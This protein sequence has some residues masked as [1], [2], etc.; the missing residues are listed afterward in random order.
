MKREEEERKKREE[1]K[2]KQ[3]GLT[4]TAKITPAAVAADGGNKD[5]MKMAGTPQQKAPALAQAAQQGQ[6]LADQDQTLQT[7]QEEKTFENTATDAAATQAREFSEKM[8]AFGS[9]GKRFENLVYQDIAEGSAGPASLD[10]NRDAVKNLMLDTADEG[11]VDEAVQVIQDYQDA[12]KRR[13]AGEAV[14]PNEVLKAGKKYFKDGG[15]G[16][17]DLLKDMFP[18]DVELD[19]AV[20]SNIAEET[21]D[22]EEMTF[23]ALVEHGIIVGFEETLGISEDD[24]KMLLG[25]DWKSM[26]PEDVNKAVA[27]QR[28]QN[29]NR[30]GRI[31]NQLNNPSLDPVVRQG[32]EEELQRLGAMGV[33]NAEQEAYETGQKLKDSDKFIVDGKVAF[34]KDYLDDTNIMNAVKEYLLIT[35]EELKAAKIEEMGEPTKSMLKWA[36]E[37][38]SSLEQLSGDVDAGIK[39]FAEIQSSNAV[40][41]TGGIIKERPLS[42]KVM[43][44]LGFGEGWQSE[45][46][47]TNTSEMAKALTKLPKDAQLD[48]ATFLNGLPESMLD[49]LAGMNA[50]EVNKIMT[51][52]KDG[53]HTKVLNALKATESMKAGA[54][55]S[56]AIKAMFGGLAEGAKIADANQMNIHMTKLQLRAEFGDRKA[57]AELAMLKNYFVMGGNEVTLNQDAINKLR[58]G[59]N[60][61]NLG[62]DLTSFIDDA[63]DVPDL[64]LGSKALES[65]FAM[66]SPN[67]V[68]L[69]ETEKTQVI[70]DMGGRSLVE[71][72]Q[73]QSLLNKGNG[74]LMRRLGLDPIEFVKAIDVKEDEVTRETM[75]PVNDMY[76][77]LFKGAW[78]DFGSDIS[79]P[80]G[81]DDM[82]TGNAMAIIFE[83]GAIKGKFDWND[84]TGFAN[85]VSSLRDCPEGRKYKALADKMKSAYKKKIAWGMNKVAGKA[86]YYPKKYTKDLL[87]KIEKYK[88]SGDPNEFTTKELGLIFDHKGS[89]SKSTIGN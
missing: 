75:G 36:E 9:L 44:K 42:P 21:I 43:E 41:I 16:L 58:D 81:M 68:A 15:S 20:A 65:I 4:Q 83:E 87:A 31:K 80:A 3:L 13:K 72:E 71:L 64:D 25:E 45:K 7:Y 55:A 49:E 10:I 84:V 82:M 69:D 89:Y 40:F 66:I 11:V 77:G 22:P 56:V 6:R 79:T 30:I 50:S 8:G 37:N 60:L 85:R 18:D 32:L 34:V 54:T 51:S 52:V 78:G 5:Q 24:I 70:N 35:D 63:V 23:D 1:E 12:V 86:K 88:K 2:A 19:Q 28:E 29:L 67:E 27:A 59:A 14:N 33:I 61:K 76:N 39:E 38:R 73:M 48:A 53:S 17:L 57:A 26:T 47:D 62:G 46:F 74:H